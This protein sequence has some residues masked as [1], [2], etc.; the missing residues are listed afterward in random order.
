MIEELKNE[1]L[2]LEND[3]RN[4]LMEKDQLL[5]EFND[6][7]KLILELKNQ[8]SKSKNKKKIH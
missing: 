2:N 6:Y 8:Q 5:K 1:I 3:N 4:L 7:E